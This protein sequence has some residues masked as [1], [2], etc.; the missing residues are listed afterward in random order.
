MEIVEITAQIQ[1]IFCLF[2]NI[3]HFKS[4]KVDIMLEK[5]F[6]I[7]PIPPEGCIAQDVKNI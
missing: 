2:Q 1:L 5:I 3:L 6:L 7:I 4:R